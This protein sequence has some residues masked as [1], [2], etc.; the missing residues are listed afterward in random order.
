MLDKRYTLPCNCPIEFVANINKVQINIVCWLLPIEVIF[1]FRFL[2]KHIEMS[3]VYTRWRKEGYY[4][5][6]AT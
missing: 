3:S 6:H 1:C 4:P 5:Q 2:I